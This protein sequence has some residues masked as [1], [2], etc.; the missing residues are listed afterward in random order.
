MEQQA[1]DT[2]PC[3]KSQDEQPSPDT[4]SDCCEDN[5]VVAD[6]LDD[7]L[8]LK[9]SSHLKSPDLKLMATVQQLLALAL[10]EEE[11]L[12]QLYLAYSSP[13]IVRDIPVLVQSFL[14]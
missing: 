3:H 7:A 9:A 2:P 5:L 8:S 6:D 13:P 10:L 1:N 11:V 12:K 14:L 4:G